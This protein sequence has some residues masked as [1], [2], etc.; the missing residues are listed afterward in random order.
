MSR[1]PAATWLLGAKQDVLASLLRNHRRDV[2]S[3]ANLRTDVSDNGRA[4]RAHTSAW[5]HTGS[6]R[7]LVGRGTPV[8]VTRP[9]RRWPPEPKRY[10]S[11]ARGR[12]G[13]SSGCG[14]EPILVGAFIARIPRRLDGMPIDEYDSPA[15][16]AGPGQSDAGVERPYVGILFECC[17]VYA[18]VYR[19]PDQKF[20][21]GRCPKC[22]RATRI[23]VGRDGIN[24]KLFRAS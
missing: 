17:G 5:L 7:R 4:H 13:A 3:P 20:Y 12:R 22:L 1:L 10:H 11:R 8:S 19:R 2:E 23:R 24:A 15:G 9:A 16:G 18:R 6:V 21:F 14:R